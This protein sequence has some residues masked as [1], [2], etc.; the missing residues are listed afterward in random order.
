[1]KRPKCVVCNQPASHVVLFEDGNNNF[2]GSA[3]C[4][5]HKGKPTDTSARETLITR[6]EG[7]CVPDT[8]ACN[9]QPDGIQAGGVQ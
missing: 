7:F 6:I 1:M 4:N 8:A 2:K 5:E 9:P 3:V